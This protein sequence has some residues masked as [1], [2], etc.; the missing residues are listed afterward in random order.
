MNEKLD[1][2]KIICVERLPEIFYQLEEIGKI[3]NKELKGIDNI[4]CNEE[5]K[6]D[7]KKRKNEITNFKNMMED[8]RKQV[9]NQIMEAYNEFNEK[10]EKEVKNQLIIAEDILRNKI[11][12]I[13]NQQKLKKENELRK[14]ATRY[15]ENKNI[16]NIVKFEDIKL[17]I[18]LSA[19]EASLKKQIV[20]F[21]EKIENDIELIK[22]EEYQEE[23]ML[24]YKKNFDFVKS[25]IE[26][27]DRHKELE[28]LKEENEI[29]KIKNEEENKIEN[30]VKETLEDEIS[31]PKEI[32]ND[33]DII[34]LTFTI[35]TTLEK[36][37]EL[38]KYLIENKYIQE[39]KNDKN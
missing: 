2:N 5:T 6:Q 13:E 14:F 29:N 23:I 32:K 31:I 33:D 24:E 3:I 39:D 25:K 19:T 35:E 28:K 37:K 36:A 38:K 26:V 9:K 15:F 21:C 10:Y 1:V 7:V 30:K 34:T 8:R 4:E 18:T 22:S 20:D 12:F 16:Q 27:L 11:I 17:N